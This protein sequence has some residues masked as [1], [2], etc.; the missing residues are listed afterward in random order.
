MKSHL[1]ALALFTLALSPLS[2]AADSSAVW[3]AADDARVAAMISADAA[4]LDAAF[5]DDLIY[6]H[7]NGKVDTKA[8]FVPAISTGKSV[9]HAV[10]YEQ[11]DFRE[12]APGLVLMTA[13]CRVQLGKTAPFNELYLSV[14][15]AYRLEKGAWRFLA[16]QSCK[17]DTAP[18]AGA[19]K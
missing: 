18:A 11:R 12:V 8:T 9:Y 13:R 5:S 3:R 6:V 4:K 2:A 17:L 1:L 15:A 19:K 10:S 14:L 7:S 16:W